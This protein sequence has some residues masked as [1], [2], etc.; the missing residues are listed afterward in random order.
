MLEETAKSPGQTISS[1]SPRREEGVT[2]GAWLSVA[3]GRMDLIAIE[4]VP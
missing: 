4:D 1:A 3:D 2:P